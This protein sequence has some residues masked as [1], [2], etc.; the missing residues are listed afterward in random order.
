MKDYAV[1]CSPSR[2]WYRATCVG[3]GEVQA[4]VQVEGISHP[5]KSAVRRWSQNT[6]TDSFGQS[7]QHVLDLRGG[8]QF[9]HL[10]PVTLGFNPS[11]GVWFASV[12]RQHGWSACRLTKGQTT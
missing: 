12:A 11:G 8:Q 3:N 6:L 7:R 10:A 2:S 1:G 9:V 5:A 4:E